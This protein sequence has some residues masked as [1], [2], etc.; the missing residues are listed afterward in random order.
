MMTHRELMYMAQAAYPD[1][2]PTMA[3]ILR[4]WAAGSASGELAGLLVGSGLSCERLSGLLDERMDELEPEHSELFYRAVDVAVR[5][6]QD[7]DVLGIHLL[8]ALVDSPGSQTTR[9]AVEAGMD[10]ERL[11]ANLRGACRR[12]LSRSSS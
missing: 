6:M 10:V 11:A 1:R 9:A 8:Q 2:R 3:R 5:S 12:S 7:G 4:A